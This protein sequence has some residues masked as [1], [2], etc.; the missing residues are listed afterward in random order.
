MLPSAR[1]LLATRPVNMRLSIDSLARV[2]IEE[3]HADPRAA[4]AV[5]VFINGKRD[6]A[7]LL[8]REATGWCLLYKRLD[9][10]LFPARDVANGVDSLAI[11]PRALASLLDGV[12]RV[13][14][15]RAGKIAVE[16]RAKAMAVV[17]DGV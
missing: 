4:G 14:K 9:T 17:V 16:S 13:R 15:E 2:V 8:W 11:E 1:V 10:H 5:Y 12:A 7:K 6:R 3:L